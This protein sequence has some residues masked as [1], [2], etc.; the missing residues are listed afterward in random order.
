MSFYL[1]NSDPKIDLAKT[2]C[3]A[4]DSGTSINEFGNFPSWA[5]CTDERAEFTFNQ[6]ETGQ[7]TL[8]VYFT[9]EYVSSLNASES[10]ENNI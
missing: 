2:E 3:V 4:Q 5:K 1:S 10:Q 9:A 7:W 8:K 6:T